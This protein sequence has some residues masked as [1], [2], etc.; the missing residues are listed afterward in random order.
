MYVKYDTLSLAQSKKKEKKRKN[1]HVYT[2][3]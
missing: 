2:K 3:D 1:V